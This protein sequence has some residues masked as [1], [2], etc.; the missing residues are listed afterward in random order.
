MKVLVIGSGAREHALVWKCVQSELVERVYCAPGNGGT[1]GMARNIPIGAADVVRMV[2]FAKRERIGLVVLGPEVAVDAGMGDAL[3]KAG[4][5][6]FGPNRGAGRIESSKS[7]AKQ[8]MARAGIPTADYAVFTDP[9]PARDWAR[10]RGG[11]VAVKADGLARGKGVI[12]CASV[13]EANAA[14]D[15]MLVQS[16]FGRSGATIV[17]EEKLQGPELSVLAIT[18]GTDVLALAPARDFKRAHDGD[19]G[20]NTGGMGA[21]SPPAGID[22]AVLDD[23]LANVLKPAVRELADSGDEFRGVLYAGLMLT[24]SGIRTLEFNA[25]FGDPEAQV[26]LPRLES[27][28]VALALAAAKGTLASIPDPKWDPRAAVGVVVASANYPDDA[29]MKTGFP[30]RGLAEMPRGV[31]VFHA[32]TRFEP[33][34][35]LV[36]DGGRVVTAVALGDTVAEAREKALA[37]ARQV[38]FQ[39]AFY[40]SDIAQEAI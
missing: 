3:R 8:L 12:V 35:G 13:D 36:T 26:V 38:R 16:R 7:F 14:I 10:E 29:L 9:A 25:R 31:Q 27:D 1:G 28:F 23:V 20:P 6:V 22:A 30:I 4:F 37:G 18:D 32:G 11:Q 15:A 21:Y 34:R 39:G 40:R 2:E 24:P 19:R 5:N 17:V 33:G